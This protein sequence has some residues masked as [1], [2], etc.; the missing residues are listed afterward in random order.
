MKKIREGVFTGNKQ[1]RTSELEAYKE[2]MEWTQWLTL[3]ANDFFGFACADAVEVDPLDLE[4]II[5]I[6]QK[7]KGDGVAAVMSFIRKCKPLKSHHT[8]EFK[9]AYK[10][11][12]KLNPQIFSEDD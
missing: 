4:W 7:Y 6:I 2:L 9:K 5:P 12:E 10:E 11:L 3:N 8:K 1:T